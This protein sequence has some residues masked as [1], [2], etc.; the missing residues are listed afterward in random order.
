M[1]GGTSWAGTKGK[2]PIMPASREEGRGNQRASSW[3]VEVGW[4]AVPAGQG[5][6]ASTQSCPPLLSEGATLH[7]G[8]SI[9]T[10][11]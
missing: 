3:K 11:Y 8:L 4:V 6:M 5:L 1:G 10:I 7:E 2:H 9:H